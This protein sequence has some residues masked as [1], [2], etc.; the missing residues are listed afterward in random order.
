MKNSLQLCF[1]LILLALT[2]FTA[3]LKE[4]DCEVCVKTVEKFASSLDEATKKD[5]KK[6][7][8]AFKKYCKTSKNKENRFVSSENQNDDV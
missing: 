4:G 3:G 2:G 6:I 5:P 7:E 8:D 1:G